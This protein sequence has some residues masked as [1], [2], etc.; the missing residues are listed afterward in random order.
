MPA[1]LPMR[2]AS[3]LVIQSA[4]CITAPAISSFVMFVLAMRRSSGMEQYAGRME[5]P[6]I[7]NISSCCFVQ[8]FDSSGS[9][10]PGS[11]LLSRTSAISRFV[12]AP[13]SFFSSTTTRVC[14]RRSLPCCG[15]RVGT[16]PSSPRSRDTWLLVP[17]V[18]VALEPFASLTHSM[19]SATKTSVARISSPRSRL[20]R[21]SASII[22]WH[23]M[24]TPSCSTVKRVCSMAAPSPPPAPPLPPSCARA[25]RRAA[26]CAAGARDHHGEARGSVSERGAPA[27]R[28][29]ATPWA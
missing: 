1:P 11:E 20:E 8:Y 19:P 29:G 10:R 6:L 3:A 25:G 17:L 12:R 2:I 13:S 7:T 23:R 16:K 4:A 22:G 15:S 18:R 24:A 21:G 28:L 5:P 9:I 14:F 26:G 27:V